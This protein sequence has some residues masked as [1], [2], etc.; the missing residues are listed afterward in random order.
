[1]SADVVYLPTEQQAALEHARHLALSGVPLFLAEP[2]LDPSGEWIP[3][4]GD[5]GTGY[6]LPRGWQNSKAD[7]R[8]VDRWRV[9]M[10]LCAVMGHVVDGVDVDPRSG[11]DR[12]LDYMRKQ[13]LLPQSYGRARTASGGVHELVASLGVRS[14]DG[15]LPGVDVKAGVDGGGHGF[16]FLA[17]T[18]KVS[19]ETGEFAP[20]TWEA[21]PDLDELVLVGPD[22][23]GSALREL[24]EGRRRR[25]YEGPE[26]DGPSYGALS[27]AEKHW[28]DEHVAGILSYWTDLLTEAVSWDDGARDESGRGWEALSRDLAWSLAR[29]AATPWVGLDEDGAELLYDDLL[30]P[31]LAADS[32]VGGKWYDGIVGKAG[33]TPIEPPP[34]D[35]MTVMREAERVDAGNDALCA[36]WLRNEIGMSGTPLA[37]LFRRGEDI[38]HTPRI[39][40]EGYVPLTADARDHD[41]PAQVR[42]AGVPR[43]RSRVQFSYNVTKFNAK[44]NRWVESVFPADAVA[45]VM[46]DVYMLPNLRVLRGVT[47]TPMLRADGTVLDSVGYDEVSARLFLPDVGLGAVRVPEAPTAGE[48]DAARSLVLSMLVDF[49]WNSPHDRANYLAGLLTPLVRELVAP[50]YKMLAINAHQR[51]SGK[52]L[53]AWVL[54]TL[55]G[56]V[57]RGDVPRDGEEFRK[58]ITSVLATTTAPVVQFDNVRHLEATQLDALLTTDLWSDRLLGR[59]AEVT[60]RNDRLWVAT[61]NNISLG[62]DLVRRVLWSS[63]DPQVPN[64]EAR[65]DFAVT[66]LKGWVRARRAELL[67]ALLTLVRAWVREGRPVGERVGEDDYARWIEA[68]RGVLAVAGIDGVIG[69][70][71]TVRQGETSDDDEWGGF[72]L[73]VQERFGDAAWS[74]GQVAE[75]GLFDEAPEGM[76]SSSARSIGKWL[77]NREGQ[78][79]SGVAVRCAGV[80]DNSKRWKV[81]RA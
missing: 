33:E 68:L 15:V 57:L 19:K 59:S 38:I 3:D 7:E 24:I 55:H 14:L 48:V 79:A 52:S 42:V 16:L 35:G 65:T 61:G 41:G 12:S 74:S 51:G 9:G 36:E 80:V 45:L 76:N 58:Q 32:R 50:P 34:W 6:W 13:G 49:P 22:G 11:G 77:T 64:P 39:D 53:L 72:L 71:D 18:V 26:Y 30:P 73:A 75:L 43:V 1:M 31:E 46:G 23:S 60:S 78:W 27:D 70:P 47:H 25:E 2:V 4:G 28:A 62:G 81:V 21:E 17:P 67:G 5:S 29:L 37:G 56:G 69:H 63:I 54:R 66:D 44:R 40:E 8:V 10:A 20:Y